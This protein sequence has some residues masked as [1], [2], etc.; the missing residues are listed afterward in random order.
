[1][2]AIAAKKRSSLQN[3]RSFATDTENALNKVVSFLGPDN[4]GYQDTS[5]V[6]A[7]APRGMFIDGQ[8]LQNADQIDT[9]LSEQWRPGFELYKHYEQAVAAPLETYAFSSHH[10]YQKCASASHS[11]NFYPQDNQLHAVSFVRVNQ[12]QDLTTGRKPIPL[13][14]DHVVHM[15]L[16]D[17]PYRGF[18]ITHVD[19]A[20]KFTQSLF[21]GDIEW[22]NDDDW[23]RTCH[24]ANKRALAQTIT[25]LQHLLTEVDKQDH[26]QQI[27]ALLDEIPQEYTAESAQVAVDF[28]RRSRDMMYAIRYALF[29]H[30]F[31]HMPQESRLIPR[32]SELTRLDEHVRTTCADLERKL[33]ARIDVLRLS[34]SASA[35]DYLM[36]QAR[37]QLKTVKL[38]RFIRRQLH[39]VIDTV[40][41][42][43]GEG[44]ISANEAIDIFQC[45][46]QTVYNP[47][48]LA[49]H[50]ALVRLDDRFYKRPRTR[51]LA[52]L[53]AT[54]AVST[55]LLGCFATLAVASF[56]LGPLALIGTAIALKIVMTAAGGTTLVSGGILSGV[57]ARRAQHYKPHNQDCEPLVGDLAEDADRSTTPI[58]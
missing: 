44:H 21:T 27:Q 49:N 17:E 48:N 58:A 16:R 34:Y 23:E 40:D 57:F 52:K 53:V 12:L 19:F 3:L 28:I 54:L 22:M 33:D 43:Q 46:L 32:Q 9:Y 8:Q 41:E 42:L 36:T 45:A 10:Y 15:R 4:V 1:M 31:M 47:M 6:N 11:V 55:L 38:S 29:N 25:D 50:R 18:S 37:A 30:Q 13:C 20:D 14:A 39:D 5:I 24:S 7:D 56:G 51:E 26:Q 2:R 35:Q